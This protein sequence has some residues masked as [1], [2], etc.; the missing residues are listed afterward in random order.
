MVRLIYILIFLVGTI[1]YAK[2]QA[3]LDDT[4]FVNI[5][6][7]MDYDEAK[8]IVLTSTRE[9]LILAN[10]SSY[11]A[12]HSQI[13]LIKADTLGNVK[14]VKTYGNVKSDQANTLI[15]CSDGNYLI[16]G[17]S[18]FNEFNDYGLITFKT[19]TSGQVLWTKNFGYE[20]WD[21]V[22]DVI[23]LEP[24]R[25]V[26]CG[27]SLT[28]G[29]SSGWL[30]AYNENTDS[31]EKNDLL[32]TNLNTTF[33]GLALASNGDYIVCGSAENPDP[34]RKRDVFVQRLSTTHD[35]LWTSIGGREEDET[36]NA[37][38]IR[39]DDTIV[40]VG[41]S[42]NP[43]DFEEDP[44]VFVLNPSTG[45]IKY[46]DFWSTNLIG[47]INDVIPG[48][49]LNLTSNLGTVE[50]PVTREDA[51]FATANEKGEFLVGTARTSPEFEDETGEALVKVDNGYYLLG[52]TKGWN[53]NYSGF[54]LIKSDSLGDVDLG[55]ISF[56][57]LPSNEDFV[58]SNRISVNQDFLTLFPNPARAG[59]R[60][61]I[62]MG[63][64]VTIETV[65]LYNTSGQLITTASS[66]HL[67]LPWDLISGLYI[68]EI[69]VR[70]ETTLRREKLI[71]R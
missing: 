38:T 23:E 11:T 27:Q 33:T 47:E 6:T 65:N 43:I 68:I 51:L 14:W 15:E 55:N 57:D 32:G 60:L 17:I 18:D 46:N 44:A 64:N 29:N 40:V 24:G 58:V 39:L 35:T 52:N 20:K 4:T 5:Y 66:N 63:R 69:E 16:S 34:T 54:F 31:V 2:G 61:Q 21:I 13:A 49:D 26:Y 53:V 1:S 19:D 62:S 59:E 9:V 30:L 45:E 50:Y 36:I 10:T 3:A 7:G 37:V 71:V 56:V 48:A 22:S 70:N 42:V 12:Q 25:F 41:K 67:N 28:L 8:D